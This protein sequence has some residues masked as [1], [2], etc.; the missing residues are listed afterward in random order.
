MGGKWKA[1]SGK[2]KVEVLDF[3]SVGKQRKAGRKLSCC[4]LG[5]AGASDVV[6]WLLDC[7]PAGK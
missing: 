3:L 7:Q 6:R 5:V 1:A 2:Q 4:R